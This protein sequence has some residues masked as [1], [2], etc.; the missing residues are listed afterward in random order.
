MPVST[1]T[2][3]PLSLLSLFGFK[4]SLNPTSLGRSRPV[5]SRSAGAGI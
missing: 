4:K 2:A 3:E 5:R 1:G